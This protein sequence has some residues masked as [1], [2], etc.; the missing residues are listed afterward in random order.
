VKVAIAGS[1]LTERIMVSS[2]N[3]PIVVLALSGRSAVYSKYNSGPKTLACGTPDFIAKL[4][5]ILSLILVL[6]SLPFM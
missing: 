4:F 6:N 3:V 2:A 1:M 5:D